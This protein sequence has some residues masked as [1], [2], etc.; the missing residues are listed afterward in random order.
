M[1]F[2]DLQRT[3]KGAYF[4]IN[5]LQLRGVKIYPY[6]LSLWVKNGKLKRLKRGIQIIPL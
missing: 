3:I 6:Q 1:K 2:Y 5:N 4:T